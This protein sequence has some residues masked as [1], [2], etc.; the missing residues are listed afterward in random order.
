MFDILDR[1]REKPRKQRQ[2]IAFSIAAAVTGVIFILWAVSFFA[3][4]QD[5]QKIETSSESAFGFDTFV[6]SFQEASN[7]IKQEVGA[8]K[9]QFD[10]INSELKKAEDGMI[11]SEAEVATEVPTEV[12]EAS[13]VEVEE[14]KTE[15]TP[16][17][18]EIIQV[19]N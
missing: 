13:V 4:I 3:S 5:N 9:E 10:F 7:T 11:S 6:D 15:I 18:I 8:A 1:I 14:S 2:A 16:S 19:E 17:G 12:G